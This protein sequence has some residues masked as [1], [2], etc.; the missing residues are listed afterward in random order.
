MRPCFVR[1]RQYPLFYGEL[2]KHRKSARGS[3][4]IR[5]RMEFPDVRRAVL[6]GMSPP[7]E[8]VVSVARTIDHRV[9]N[10]TAQGVHDDTAFS[11][12]TLADYVEELQAFADIEYLVKEAIM[13]VSRLR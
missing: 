12:S 13:T 7:F 10:Y 3:V 1:F 4:T 11:L 8:T 6:A 5:L 9:A 2:L